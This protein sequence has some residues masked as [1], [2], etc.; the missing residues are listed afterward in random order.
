[1]A[2]KNEGEA[3]MLV[4]KKKWDKDKGIINGLV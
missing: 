4:A 3:R 1:M 2:Y